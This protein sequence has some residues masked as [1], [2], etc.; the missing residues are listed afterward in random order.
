MLRGCRHRYHYKIW[1]DTEHGKQRMERGT[2]AIPDLETVIEDQ[3]QVCSAAR[4]CSCRSP[5]SVAVGAGPLWFSFQLG[6]P[7]RFHMSGRK[8]NGRPSTCYLPSL[9]STLQGGCVDIGVQCPVAPETC[10]GLQSRYVRAETQGAARRAAASSA[11]QGSMLD[12]QYACECA[13]LALISM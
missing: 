7:V 2:D 10:N 1:Q 3:K 13:R 12:V 11:L 4:P 6:P 5:S 8:C 9:A